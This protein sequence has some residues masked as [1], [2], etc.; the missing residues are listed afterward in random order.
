[1]AQIFDIT[2]TINPSLAVWPGDTPFSAQVITAI[3]AGS[4]INL[5]TLTMSSH[6]GTHVDA[7]Y[8]FL[9]NDLTMEQAP[10][11]AYLGPAT[12]VTV[13]RE[14]GPLLPEDFP[15]LEWSGVQRLLVHSIASARP[16]DQFP[17]EFVYPSPE[18]AELMAQ[19]GV[20]LFG[21]DAPSM[22]DM[23]SK[24]LPGHKALRRHRIAILEG[25][26]LAGVP[27]GAYELIALPL[28]IAGGDGSPVRAIL[29]G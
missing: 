5:T 7:P 17:T 23:N 12:V 22:D 13:Q 27:D 3:K 28:K 20:V 21:S 14:A 11:E 16:L 8:H 2:R 9:D 25:L 15:G 26:L 18:L 6:L 1:M 10:L 29:R 24:T 19:H 4:S